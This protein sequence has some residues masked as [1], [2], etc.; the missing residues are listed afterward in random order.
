M[1]TKTILLAFCWAL[2]I[3]TVLVVVIFL[4]EQTGVIPLSN[5]TTVNV[6]GGNFIR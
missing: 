1:N 3:I 6:T 5:I 2:L 4:L